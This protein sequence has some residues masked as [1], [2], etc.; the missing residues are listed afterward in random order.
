MRRAIGA[1]IAALVIIVVAVMLGAFHNAVARFAC[2]TIGSLVSGYQIRLGEVRLNAVHGAFVDV[3][4]RRGPDPVL[5]ARRIDVY[6]SLRDLLPGSKHRFGLHAV[7]IDGPRV[8][9]VHHENGT[10]NVSVP[11]GG[12]PSR[13]PALTN[14]VPLDFTLRVRGAS[15]RLID[16]YRYYE[17]S[18]YQSI[19]H[20]DANITV[21]SANVSKYLVT[22]LLQD[23]G[24][25]RL[26]MAGTIDNVRHYA[27]HHVTLSAIPIATIG[28]YFIN[29]PA[30]H[31]LGGTVR[32]MDM[33]A[34]SYGPG[35]A[36]HMSGSGELREGQM[37]VHSLDSPIR[38]LA[39]RITLFD[40]GFASKRLT[41]D[42]GHLGI[43]CS[44]GIFDFRSPQ[45]RLGIDGG[46]DLRYLKDVLKIAGG[47]PIFGPVRI[48]ALIEGNINDPVLLIGFNGPRFNYGAV[49]IDDPRGTVAIYKNNLI[50]LPFH[51]SYSGIALHVH[52]N[53]VLGK[54]VTSVLTLHAVGPAR[55]IPYLGSLISD[56][57]VLI[58]SL[59]TGTDLK[60]DARGYLVSLQNV[61]AVNGF[62]NLNRY[63]VGTFGPIGMTTPAGGSLV[64][65]FSLDRPHGGSTFWASARNVR[66]NQP[67]PVVLPG[68]NIPQ[69]PPMDAHIVEANIAGTGSAHNVVVGG[70]VYMS[71][72]SIAGVPFNTI[73]ARFA[74]PFAASQL[75]QVHADGPWGTFDGGGTFAPNLIVARGNYAGTLEGLHMFLGGFPATGAISGPMG[76]AIAQGKIFVQAQNA[77]LRNANIHGIPISAV[78]GTMSFDKGILRVFSA[79]AHAAGGEVVA[80]GSFATVPSRTP[81]RL[82][83]AT[84]QLNAGALHGFGVPLSGGSLRA[85]GAVAP[86][87]AIPNVDAGVVLTNGS[88]AGYGPFTTSSEIAIA[89]DTL[90][91]RDTT[92]SLGPTFANVSGT[93][94][95]LAA[96][97]PAYDI[98][99]GVPVGQIAPMARL[100]R[101]PAF[102][103]D[104]SFQGDL[105]ITGSG[106]NP[107]IEGIAGVPVGELNGLGFRDAHARISASRAGA[108]VRDASVTVGSTAL[109]FSATEAKD[110]IAFGMQSAHAD[111]SDFNDY[112]NT[113]DTLAGTG[114]VAISFAHLGHLTFTSGEV[115]IAGLRYRRLPI[116]DTDARWN[117][118][119]N[120]VHGSVSIGGEHGKLRASGT[121]GFAQSAALGQVVARSRYDVNAALS[122]L[123]LTTW[124]P[125]LGFPQLP[126]T[127]RIDGNAQ[128][129]GAYPHIALAGNASIR[130]GTIGPLP[131]ER[132][133]VYA[134]SAPGDRI[135]VTRLAVTFPAMEATGAGSFGITPSAPMQMQIH[136]VTTDLAR[137]VSLVSKKRLPL[138][139][140]FESTV[141][142]GGSF[143]SPT[144]A[145]GVDASNVDA[146][147]LA[148]PSFVGQLQLSRRDL[149][150]RNAEFTFNRGRATIAG[151]LPLQ[152]QPFSFGPINA[153]IAMDM[154]ADNVDLS[155][156]GTFLGNGTKLAGTIN[157]HVGV[158]GTVR[159]PQIFGQL[160][161]T[162]VSYA[163]NIELTP[164]THTVAQLTFEGTHARLDQLQ[165]LLGRGSVTG[166]GSLN[167]GGGLNGGPLEYRINIAARG[168]QIDMPQFGSGTFNGQLALSR[169]DDTLAQLRGN[170][171]VTDAVMP[172]AAF[173][174]FGGSS[175]AASKGPP[176]NLALNLGITAGRNVR[177]R[178]GGA[179]IFGLD[180]SGAGHA[181]LSGTLLHPIMSGQFNSTGGTLVYIDH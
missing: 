140:R 157:G 68:A 133:Q 158:S 42:V 13:R 32:G 163:S 52:G 139:G 18:R 177:V 149:V 141:S 38:H 5:D 155:P 43:V 37:F 124:L 47:L 61:S 71:P 48:H 90:H 95:N 30:A 162:D 96:G 97:T 131:I 25:Q 69:L 75:N 34:W 45:F 136:A 144:F 46:G 94:S 54:Q 154:T 36:L 128:I 104:G 109:R 153:P 16:Q 173:L 22:G 120:Q 132:G 172:F 11:G 164:I 86:G 63:G 50:V 7:T 82:A 152:L 102:N 10:Y 148:I 57:P 8:T 49:P 93:M 98:V 115:D 134:R 6:Y 106:T 77:Q 14:T 39:G 138:T 91:V 107:R 114:A 105:R 168:A 103:A 23:A 89:H 123:D 83:L 165:A 73:A 84:T 137:L 72:A 118:L 135:E 41:A 79:Q 121:I 62:Y 167:F 17:A 147:G 28:N 4:V 74:G 12:A 143:R 179:G 67:V 161:A 130:D 40:S 70:A 170:V 64:A 122:N 125:A 160:A 126:V 55:R 88:A 2:T 178:G 15:A 92:A 85:V 181:L 66:L 111:L 53:L 31:I 26:R 119:R 156:F 171:T 110:E 59:L 76:I 166:S 33:Y 99:A 27:L 112:F 35:G 44:G 81:T 87:A 180:I 116:G 117:S 29:S 142:I 100:A 175:G 78:T 101:V 58:E 1:V 3:H 108:T 146:F 60:V 159:N 127:G 174:Q 21:A 20:I 129:R 19:D 169:Q 151:S 51:A 150:V 113:G 24:A 176:F 65:G 56:Q 9:I 145:A 80:A